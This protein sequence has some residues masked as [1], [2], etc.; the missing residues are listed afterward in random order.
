MNVTKNT[1]RKLHFVFLGGE[2][3]KSLQEVHEVFYLRLCQDMNIIHG[4]C[5]ETSS[6]SDEESN[7]EQETAELC[8]YFKP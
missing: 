7:S 4:K 6:Q 1:I 8:P 3:I 2:N 5:G